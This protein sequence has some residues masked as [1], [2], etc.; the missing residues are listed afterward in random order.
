VLPGIIDDPDSTRSSAVDIASLVNFH[1]VGVPRSL[2]SH[3]AKDPVRGQRQQPRR[4]YIEGSNMTTAGIIDVQDLLVW[5][6]AQAIGE[7]KIAY[8]QVN[9]FSM[10]V[11][12]L[13]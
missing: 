13:S 8:Q 7:N 1:A 3:G 4:F 6:K 11:T 12:V 9:R 5:G 10:S 2:T